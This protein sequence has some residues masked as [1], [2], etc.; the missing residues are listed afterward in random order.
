MY[1]EWTKQELNEEFS[2]RMGEGAS[3]LS[4]DEIIQ[5]LEADDRDFHTKIE[6]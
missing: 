5:E 6:D 2:Y 1:D 3:T 4:R